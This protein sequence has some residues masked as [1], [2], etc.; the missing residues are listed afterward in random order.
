VQVSIVILRDLCPQ[1]ILL[2]GDSSMGHG[3]IEYLSRAIS[4]GDPN[5]MGGMFSIA[6]GAAIDLQDVTAGTTRQ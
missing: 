2:S 6:K 5:S 3:G 1:F 4:L